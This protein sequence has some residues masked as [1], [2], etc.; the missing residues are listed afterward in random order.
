MHIKADMR[1]PRGMGEKLLLRHVARR[2]GLIEASVLWKRAIQF[3]AR[4]AKMTNE[5]RGEKGNMK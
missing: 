3:G 2:L 4:T 1:Y 5:S